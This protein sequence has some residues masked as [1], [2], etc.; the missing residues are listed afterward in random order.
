V[1]CG[2]HL[3]DW[4]TAVVKGDR[5]SKH[6]T[7]LAAGHNEIDTTGGHS[8]YPVCREAGS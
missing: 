5:G 8:A 2:S 3:N 1:S 6:S 7:G 4:L